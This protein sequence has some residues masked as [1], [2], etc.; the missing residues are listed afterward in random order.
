MKQSEKT[1]A[2]SAVL[3]FK[4]I[5]EL[6]DLPSSAPRTE[7]EMCYLNGIEFHAR[8]LVADNELLKM[9]P[10][11]EPLP[12]RCVE[13]GEVA[14]GADERVKQIAAETLSHVVKTGFFG[15][16][17]ISEKNVLNDA[18]KAIK[19]AFNLIEDKPFSA[20]NSSYEYGPEESATRADIEGVGYDGYVKRKYYINGAHAGEVIYCY[21]DSA[22]IAPV[23]DVDTSVGS[24]NGAVYDSGDLRFG[25]LCLIGCTPVPSRGHVN[26]YSRACYEKNKF[27]GHV[28]YGVS[29]TSYDEKSHSEIDALNVVGAVEKNAPGVN[30]TSWRTDD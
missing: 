25:D 10:A 5:D 15:N 30:E 29:K 14:L 2:N 26:L 22:S 19:T 17:H 23:G 12:F 16:L 24:H 1:E 4:F 27:I 3:I 13:F 9:G 21:K 6:R 7:T 28:Y 20:I 8:K 11:P 18:A